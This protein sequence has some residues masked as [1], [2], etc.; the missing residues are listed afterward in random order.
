MAAST[1]KEEQAK[2][3]SLTPEER[4]LIIDRISTDPRFSNAVFGCF[5]KI[6][7][8]LQDTK[9]PV[10]PILH[11]AFRSETIYDQL[12][13]YEVSAQEFM[14]RIARIQTLQGNR[15]FV[16]SFNDRQRDTRPASHTDYAL[17]IPEDESRSLSQSLEQDPSVLL[18]VFKNVYPNYNRSQGRLKIDPNHPQIIPLSHEHIR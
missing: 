12:F 6:G 18:E 15:I 5:G 3:D 10:E 11:E 9:G 2:N 16:V 8:Y 17:I 7:H 1:R 4:R 13:R 14:A